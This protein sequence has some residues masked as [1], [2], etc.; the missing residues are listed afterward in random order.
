MRK[1][2]FRAWLKDEKRMV[3]VVGIDWDIRRIYY[4]EDCYLMEALFNEIELMQFTGLCDKNGKKIFEGDILKVYA[5]LVGKI[6]F[7]DATFFIR[8]S[9][10]SYEELNMFYAE[11]IE[12]IGNIHDNPELLEEI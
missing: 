7:V 12:I 1:I 8:Y 2:E 4:N 10:N 5:K 11:E 3:K 6:E 9:K